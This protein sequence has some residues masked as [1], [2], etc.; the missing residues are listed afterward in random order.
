MNTR[1]P[2]TWATVAALACTLAATAQAHIAERRTMY[3]TFSG[4]V[5]LPG[6]TL[7]AGTYIFERAVSPNLVRVSS[8]DRSTVFLTAFTDPV[9]RP[10][11]L[12]PDRHLMFR[13][14]QRGAAPP[15]RAWFPYNERTGHAFIYDR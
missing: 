5:A 1:K 13:E 11:G 6:V 9:E 14:S 15:I 8:R 2:L 4:P 7:A 3:V 10:E 12:A